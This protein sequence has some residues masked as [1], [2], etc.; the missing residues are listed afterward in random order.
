MVCCGG[1]VDWY[2]GSDWFD[3]STNSY[4]QVPPAGSYVYL[5]YDNTQVK[6]S[7]TYSSPLQQLE[8]DAPPVKA[9]TPC[10]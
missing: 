7:G 2:T 9:A 5:P 3:S 8:L 6:F 4:G 1:S 10:S